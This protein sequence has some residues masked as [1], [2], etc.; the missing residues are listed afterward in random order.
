MSMF[1]RSDFSWLVDYKYERDGNPYNEPIN[2]YSR[3]VRSVLKL[4]RKSGTMYITEYLERSRIIERFVN[5]D[6]LFDTEETALSYLT[7]TVRI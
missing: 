6:K 7:K 4:Y 2:T 5:P 3:F 1:L